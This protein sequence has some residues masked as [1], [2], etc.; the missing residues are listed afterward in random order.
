[1][2]LVV[3]RVDIVVVCIEAYCVQELR[4]ETAGRHTDQTWS[5]TT[6]AAL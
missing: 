5:G 2:L 3:L 6:T 4:R 1:M